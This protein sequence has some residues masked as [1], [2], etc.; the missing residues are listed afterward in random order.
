ME[1][2]LWQIINDNHPKCEYKRP[3]R[4]ILIFIL[5]DFS[6]HHIYHR[7]GLV[8]FFFIM[9]VPWTLYTC[10]HNFHISYDFMC[11]QFCIYIRYIRVD[12]YT[13]EGKTN[14]KLNTRPNFKVKITYTIRPLVLYYWNT[15]RIGHCDRIKFY[16]DTEKKNKK[17]RIYTKAVWETLAP[18]RESASVLSLEYRIRNQLYTHCAPY[19]WML[20][21]I[22]YEWLGRSKTVY[23]KVWHTK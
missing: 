14:K 11:V 19:P 5:S 18:Y 9:R 22:E 12:G 7:I 4:F 3:Y 15:T 17:K 8:R 10:I 21:S 2:T 13:H 23:R 20:G 6:N 16:S 1:I